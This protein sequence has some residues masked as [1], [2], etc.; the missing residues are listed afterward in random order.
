MRKSLL[1]FVVIAAVPAMLMAWPQPGDPAPSVTLPDTALATH[2]IPGDDTGHVL[3]LFFWK[4]TDSSSLAE[5]P[6]VQAMYDD[7]RSRGYR[8]FAINLLE[9]MDSV[10]KVFARRYTYTFLL[11]DASAWMAYKMDGYIPLNYVVDTAGLVA[12]SMEGFNETTIRGWIEAC[13]PGVSETHAQPLE[14]TR[15]GAN[16]VV[17]HSAVRFN[18]PKAANVR[19]RVYSASGALV[20]TLCNGQMPAGANAVS[21]NLHDNAG[22]PV[23]SGLYLY[24]LNTGSRSARAKVSVLK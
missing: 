11:D 15:I 9:D 1:A 21:W 24:E 18:L 8:P 20:R 14:F 19:L 12:G 3:Q 23:G 17:G 5:L 7:Y 6:R 16:P 4:S 13:L 22:R 10:V 2:V